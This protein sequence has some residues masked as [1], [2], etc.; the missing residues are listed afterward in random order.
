MIKEQSLAT[1]KT[2]RDPEIGDTVGGSGEC[3]LLSLRSSKDRY[4]IHAG[5]PHMVNVFPGSK[6]VISELVDIIIRCPE[7]DQPPKIS[8]VSS[9]VLNF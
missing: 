4:T 2:A 3:E 8:Q 5:F 6:H 7:A 1:S 9:E